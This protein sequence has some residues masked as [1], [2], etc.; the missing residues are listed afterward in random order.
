MRWAMK[1]FL[2]LAAVLTLFAAGTDKIFAQEG[3]GMEA[4]TKKIAFVIARE[5]FRDEELFIT[6]KTVESAGFKVEI[7][8]ASTGRATGM[9]GGTVDVSLTLSDLKEQDFD[10]V[11]FVGGSGADVYWNAPAAHDIAKKF[12]AAGKIVAAI[13]IAPVTLAKAGLLKGKKATA[14]P[15]AESQL[16]NSG[17]RYT[18]ASVEKDGNIITADGPQSAEKFGRA[19]A[20]ALGIK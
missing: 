14:F 6:K 5:R 19:I 2:I 11:V 17:C 12:Y 15:S 16:K 13:C 3:A 8:S 7:F 1:N 9:L 4:K 10:A 18:G 20:E